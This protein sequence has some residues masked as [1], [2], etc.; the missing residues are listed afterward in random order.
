[1][2]NENEY[3]CLKGLQRLGTLN[4]AGEKLVSDMEIQMQLEG[5]GLEI[6]KRW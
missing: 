5:R 1:M 2:A 6:E 4:E 3:Q